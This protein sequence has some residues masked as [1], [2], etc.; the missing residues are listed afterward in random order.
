MNLEELTDA[1]EFSLNGQKLK[2]KVVSVYDGDTCKIILPFKGEFFKWN[3][4]LNNIDTPELRTKNEK[5]KKFGYFV[6]DKVRNMILNKII[7]VE[8]LSF[9]KYGRLLVNLT[10][11]EINISDYLIENGY[12]FQYEGKTKKSWGEFLENKNIDDLICEKK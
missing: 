3:C 1:K 11:E 12:A 8:C 7:D 5:E 6:R 9:D 2:G 10:N 4:R